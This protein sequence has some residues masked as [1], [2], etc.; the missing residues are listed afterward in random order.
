MFRFDKTGRHVTD[1]PG[2]W[3]EEDCEITA[4]QYSDPSITT[5]QHTNGPARMFIRLCRDN[6]PWVATQM[7][8]THKVRS[9]WVE[10]GINA[11]LAPDHP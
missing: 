11:F 2:L 3:S 1:L 9:L 6:S 4:S 10:S 7:Y 5:G 8:S